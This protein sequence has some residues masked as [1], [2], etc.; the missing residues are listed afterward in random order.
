MKLTGREKAKKSISH[1]DVE[2]ISDTYHDYIT[3]IRTE[4]NDATE[5]GMLDAYISL[6]VVNDTHVSFTKLFFFRPSF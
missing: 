5:N 6:Y 3:P 1:S 2:V 4:A